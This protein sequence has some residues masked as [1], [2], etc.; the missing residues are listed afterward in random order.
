MK[1][2]ERI[3]SLS[4]CTAPKTVEDVG[5]NEGGMC[6]DGFEVLSE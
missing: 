4:S 5:L 1:E 3:F 6:D 2:S